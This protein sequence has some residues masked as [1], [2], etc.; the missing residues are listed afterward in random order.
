MATNNVTY[1]WGDRWFE[2]QDKATYLWP[3]TIAPTVKATAGVAGVA[4]LLRRIGL[5][6]IAAAVVAWEYERIDYMPLDADHSGAWAT[7]RSSCP[8]AFRADRRPGWHRGPWPA[9]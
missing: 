2:F 6:R 4:N 1:T 3:A 5:R 9:A 7:L 8:W